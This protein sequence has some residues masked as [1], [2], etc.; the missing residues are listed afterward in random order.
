MQNIFPAL[1]GSKFTDPTGAFKNVWKK[2]PGRRLSE[3]QPARPHQ[4]TMKPSGGCGW[5]PVA[6]R[7]AMRHP[8]IT[9]TNSPCSIWKLASCSALTSNLAKVVGLVQ[10]DYFNDLFRRHLTPRQNSA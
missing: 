1:D 7:Q 8:R 6:R 10:P 3:L 2:R 5:R 9:A 4:R